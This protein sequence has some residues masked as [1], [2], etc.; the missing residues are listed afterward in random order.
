MTRDPGVNSS[1]DFS[2]DGREIS[3]HSARH[4]TRDVYVINADGS[5]E[6]RLTSD[7]EQS[8]NPAFSPD[9]LRIAYANGPWT[10]G[11]GVLR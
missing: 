10:T 2:P 9:G 4:G 11:G 8:Y 6:R 1:P 5:D 7:E 3:F